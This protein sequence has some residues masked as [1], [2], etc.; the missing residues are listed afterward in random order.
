VGVVTKVEIKKPL[1][2]QAEEMAGQLT[3]NERSRLRRQADLL[4]SKT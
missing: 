3:V 2:L 1:G 4:H